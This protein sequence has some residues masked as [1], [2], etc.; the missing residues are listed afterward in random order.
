MSFLLLMSG[1]LNAATQAKFDVVPTAGTVY[2]LLLPS[3]FKHDV[4]Y[5]VTN[6][7][8]VTRTL[9]TVPV[10][11]VRQI[12]TGTGA[13]SSPFT[14]ASQQS[15]LLNLQLNASQMSAS[16]IL[17]GPVVCKNQ[18]GNTVS[19]DLFLCSDPSL[20]NSLGVS[21]TNPEQ[22]VYVV[23]QGDGSVSACQ[24][25][26]VN[27]LFGSCAVVATGFSAPEALAMNSL[28]TMLY[29]TDTGTNTI[30]RCPVDNATGTVGTC[31]DA[32]GTGFTLPS[33]VAISPDGSVL[34]ASNGG[35]VEAVTACNI[36]AT[37]GGLSGCAQHVIP[38]LVT[39]FDLTLNNAGNKLYIADFTNSTISVCRADA[40][41][42]DLCNNTSGNN[43]DGPE[44]VTLSPSGEHLYVTNNTSN[45]VT[46]CVVDVVTGLLSACNVTSGNFNGTGNVALNRTGE[47]VYIPNFV[48]NQVFFCEVQTE[49]G[50]LFDCKDSLGSG[51]NRPA[52]VLV[53]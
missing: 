26:P 53:H 6:K 13:C 37:T 32:G 52:G 38:G 18:G 2:R 3:N 42:V 22:Y 8:Q 25:D 29:V 33:G 36:D 10:T 21:V 7:T 39:A 5:Q 31:V 20:E 50:E 43:F 19:P 17:G 27:R 1:V 15:C 44:G 45:A 34:Y 23:N 12:T 4:Q 35:G 9:T 46:R 41:T 28:G 14:L 49:T 40:T 47:V 48:L 51:F 11:G 30:S 16:G 24:I